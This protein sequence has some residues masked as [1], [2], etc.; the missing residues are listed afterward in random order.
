M[1][2]VESKAQN[3]AISKT[4][5]ETI[6][7]TTMKLVNKTTISQ[8]ELNKITQKIELVAPEA[9]LIE[10]TK[11]AAELAKVICV[12]KNYPL[13]EVA[14]CAAAL[15]DSIAPKACGGG[16]KVSQDGSVESETSA[17]L[18]TV[19]SSNLEAAMKE[20]LKTEYENQQNGTAKAIPGIVGSGKSDVKNKVSNETVNKTINQISTEIKN[21]L[22][23]FQRKNNDTSQNMIIE[24]FPGM[25]SGSCDFSQNAAIKSLS[26]VGASKAMQIIAKVK[27]EKSVETKAKNKQVAKAISEGPK[28]PSIIP[29]LIGVAVIGGGAFFIMQMSKNNTGGKQRSQPPPVQY[30][31]PPQPQVQY[32]QSPAIPAGAIY[33]VGQVITLPNGQTAQIQGFGR[34][35]KIKA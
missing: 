15:R 32:Q 20:A 5:N 24:M 31:Q 28:M 35:R 27:A 21:E 26:N 25:S 13:D 14:K 11:E 2:S 9:T 12:G 30:Q 1:G 22:E 23:M 10:L 3:E 7:S 19:D 18:K 8:E 33:K 34:R 17:K 4:I 29:L 6:N 16:L